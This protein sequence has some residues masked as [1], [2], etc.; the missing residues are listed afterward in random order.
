LALVQLQTIEFNQKEAAIRMTGMLAKSMDNLN[1]E[2]NHGNMKASMF[3]INIFRLRQ[4]PPS[5]SPKKE[6][7]RLR[8]CGESAG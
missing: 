7:T 4:R 5:T 3:V 2:V 6:I 8:P 1:N